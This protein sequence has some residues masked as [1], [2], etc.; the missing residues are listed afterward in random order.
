MTFYTLSSPVIKDAEDGG[1]G[2]EETGRNEKEGAAAMLTEREKERGNIDAMC[3]YVCGLCVC[4]LE[5]G[6]R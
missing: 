4:V 2:T 1:G 6:R 3:A 5:K